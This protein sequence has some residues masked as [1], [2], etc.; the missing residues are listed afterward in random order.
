MT[1]LV[2]VAAIFL[3]GAF[4]AQAQTAPPAAS[5]NAVQQQGQKLFFQSCGVCHWKPQITA[6]LFAPALSRETASGNESAIKQIIAGG[7]PRM[8]GFKHQF[9]ETQIA[10][11]AAYIMA[12]PPAP[13]TPAPASPQR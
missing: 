1:G 7:T 8:P 9:D 6:P 11:I 13:P 3:A 2:R 5:L 12:I 10:S 4:A